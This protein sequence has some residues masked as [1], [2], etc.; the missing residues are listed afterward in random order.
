DAPRIETTPGLGSA[1]MPLRRDLTPTS[2]WDASSRVA[3]WPEQEPLL[4]N[5]RDGPESSEAS[6][7]MALGE[8]AGQADDPAAL[9]EMLRQ[10]GIFE[11]PQ[12][13][14]PAWT[15]S[16]EVTRTGTRLGRTL[17]VVWASTLVLASVGCLRWL[18]WV[19]QRHAQAAQLVAEAKADTL[20]GD[21]AKLVDAERL[22]RLA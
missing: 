17:I 10:H 19:S 5:G 18:Q 6:P 22:L 2:S 8:Q 4:G 3:A 20:E 11:P 16:R 1:P 9:L 12:T 14:S 21:Y 7:D 13:S 15:T